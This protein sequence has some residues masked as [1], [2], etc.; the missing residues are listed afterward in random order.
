[1]SDFILL[2]Y[3]LY[4]A[5]FELPFSGRKTIE[6][7]VRAYRTT[8]RISRIAHHTSHPSIAR[9]ASTASKD[10]S[11]G[12]S[13]DDFGSFGGVR[14]DAVDAGK[15][16][17]DTYAL[18]STGVSD[19]SKLPEPVFILLALIVFRLA[20]AYLSSRHTWSTRSNATACAQSVVARCSSWTGCLRSP[21]CT[22]SRV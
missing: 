3:Y 8:Y 9:P 16:V 1:M 12:R 17:R 15:E 18:R 20:D 6:R 21:N 13:G 14:E 4:C 11:F 7:A 19:A 22:S 10:P 5:E 2:L